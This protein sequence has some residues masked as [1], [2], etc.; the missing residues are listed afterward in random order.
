MEA[1][2]RLACAVCGKTDQLCMI[3]TDSSDGDIIAF[4]LSCEGCLRATVGAGIEVKLGTG[5]D[6]EVD[7]FLGG[8]G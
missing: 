5:L 1:G 7:D 8:M 4:L 3:P 2:T 6:E